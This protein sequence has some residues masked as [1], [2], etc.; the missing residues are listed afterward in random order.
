MS[1]PLIQSMTGHA[2]CQGHMAHLR[3]SLSVRSVNNKSL[4]MRIRAPDWIEARLRKAIKEAVTRGSVNVSVIIEA[5]T[6]QPRSG[7]LTDELRT[8]MAALREIMEAAKSAG[9][10]VAAPNAL[11][12]YL[13]FGFEQVDRLAEPEEAIARAIDADI[14]ALMTGWV[15]TRQQEGAEL[16]HVIE[17]RLAHLE[18]L[19]I[20]A[21]TSA[22]AR[23]GLVRTRIA[24]ACGAL[25]QDPKLCDPQRL[26][27]ELAVIFLKQD[28]REELDRLSAHISAARLLLKN[29]GVLG[30]KFEFLLQEFMREAN[31]LC[32]KANDKTLTALGLDIKLC[33]D[34][35]REQVLN[36]E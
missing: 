31:T 26:E 3:W 23:Q 25:L 11:D 33:I 18:R 13:K 22:Q 20:S 21:A 6:E 35:M 29:G 19:L 8:H 15:T 10:S 24:E 1:V 5:E 30:R 2:T 7:A 16:I 36:L 14:A 17:A 9:L 27:Q 34:Q 28:I 32:S 4:D 12:L